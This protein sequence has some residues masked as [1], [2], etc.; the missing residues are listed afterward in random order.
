VNDLSNPDG[1]KQRSSAG[2]RDFK[3]TNRGGAS[4]DGYRGPPK[5]E[6]ERRNK[7]GV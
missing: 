5:S 3:K 2:R 7:R 6:R 4:T 1:S